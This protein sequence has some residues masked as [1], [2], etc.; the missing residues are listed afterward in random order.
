MDRL[1]FVLFRIYNYVQMCREQNYHCSP[2]VDGDSTDIIRVR[3]GNVKSSLQDYFLRRMT[4]LA[5]SKIS[6][7]S[8]DPP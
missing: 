8:P 7:I 4:V 6:L 5:R 2:H 3:M 1:K